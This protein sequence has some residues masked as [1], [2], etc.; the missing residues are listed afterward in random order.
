MKYWYRHGKWSSYP[1]GVYQ[2]GDRVSE[3]R[4]PGNK[5]GLGKTDSSMCLSEEQD[6]P[7]SLLPSLKRGGENSWH[8]EQTFI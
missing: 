3:L 1:A 5:W 7:N 4:K 2:Q 8:C 6:L